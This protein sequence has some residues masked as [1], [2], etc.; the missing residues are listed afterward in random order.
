MESDFPDRFRE[1][2]LADFKLK[3]RRRSSISGPPSLKVCAARRAST[4]STESYCRY[5]L[6]LL[7]NYNKFN[8]RIIILGINTFTLLN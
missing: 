6:L 3:Q 8:N 5:Q 1:E 2:E 4:I 7:Y